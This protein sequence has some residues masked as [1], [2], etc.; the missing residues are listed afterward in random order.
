MDVFKLHGLG[1]IVG[2]FL[3]G[4]FAS[5]SVAM[6]DGMTSARGAVDG[7]AIQIGYQLADIC[8]ISSYSFV[9][10]VVILYA[11]QHIPG[12]KLRVDE[13]VE[14]EGLDNHEFYDEEVGDWSAVEKIHGILGG[15]SPPSQPS[16]P[17]G[18]T[19]ENLA[20]KE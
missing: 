2:S 19:Q 6:L 3:T 20:A 8:A 18:H 7:N 4:I 16:T 5:D 11:M 13:E 10:S 12:L 9:V 14:V 17:I 1:G 15:V